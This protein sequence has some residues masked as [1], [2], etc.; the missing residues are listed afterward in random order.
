MRS[1]VSF[2][3]F[4]FLVL[5]IG[6]HAALAASV[7]LPAGTAI[8][9]RTAQQIDA[10]SAHVG[11]RVNGVVDDPIDANGHV[12]IP[13]GSHAVLE[14]VGVERSTNMKGRDRIMLKI[15][16]V[17]VG[18]H[19]YAVATNHVEIKGPSEGKR[20]RNKILGGAGIG[21]AVGGMIGGGTGAVVGA[22]TGGGV[23]AVV[24]NSGKTHLSVPSETVVQFRLSGALRVQG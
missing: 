21:A 8:N 3:V 23:G 13:R 4:S 15:H 20:A 9:I 2:V 5:A 14:V 17:G 11:M 12:V 24:A 6:Q 18:S 16:S 22:T 10:D 7:T 1:H 19:A